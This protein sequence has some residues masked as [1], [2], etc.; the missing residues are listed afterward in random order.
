MNVPYVNRAYAC[1]YFPY[2]VQPSRFHVSMTHLIEQSLQASRLPSFMT[3]VTRG[4]F[5]GEKIFPCDHLLATKN[6][7]RSENLRVAR[8]IP[9]ASY[10]Q[11]E[12]LIGV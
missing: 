11:L 7:S 1:F 3:V 12:K 2:E 6:H 8:E 4:E 9:F 10:S 5:S